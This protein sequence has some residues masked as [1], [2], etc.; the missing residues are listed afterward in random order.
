MTMASLVSDP[1][2]RRRIQWVGANGK[3]QQIR[4]G[5]VDKR[6]AERIRLR[7][8]SLVSAAA[9]G[10]APDDET[11]KWV[12]G[13]SDQLHERL[14]GV[15]LVQPRQQADLKG[16]FDT[17]VASHPEW[18]TH[19]KRNVEQA[20]KWFFE[21]FSES[22]PVRAITKANADAFHGFLKKSL[23][24]SN[25]VSSVLKKV[26]QAFAE[27]VAAE[28][29]GSNPFRHIKSPIRSNP[30]RMEFV[31]PEWTQPILD[32]CPDIEWKVIFAMA[33]YAGVRVP[34]ELQEFKWGD[35][36]W[37]QDRI[38]IHDAKRSRPGKSVI[39]II[40]MFTELRPLLVEAYDQAEEGSVYVCPR[41]R[42]GST[43]LRTQMHRIIKRAGLTPWQRT[44]Q[45]MRSTR[46]TELAEHF[47]MHVVTKWIGNTD[48]VAVQHYLQVTN[49]HFTK[50][51]DGQFDSDG[52]DID[53]DA[54]FEEAARNQAQSEQNSQEPEMTDDD[55]EKPQVPE[56]SGTCGQ[57]RC[58]SLSD[59]DLQVP[60]RGVEPLSSG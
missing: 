52:F 54:I 47:P 41:S 3:R 42:S 1:N 19:T 39:R 57:S 35:I 58:K 14:A 2:G 56:E 4:L 25:S 49:D 9:T 13:L 15:G 50:A 29:V 34:S 30:E 7:I 36:L 53:V 37:D 5:Q 23:D 16:L 27:A 18:G 24:S 55:N 8:E 22:T 28:T 60:P 45:N 11:K 33:R 21:H 59:K 43:N 44:F 46:E 38:R 26:K 31:K 17:F 40:P 48:S 6:M 20:R 32:A 12:D 10:F 51:A